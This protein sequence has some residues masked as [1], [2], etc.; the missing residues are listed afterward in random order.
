MVEKDYNSSI[1]LINMYI[2]ICMYTYY[3]YTHTHTHTHKP[4]HT[5]THTGLRQTASHRPCWLRARGQVWRYRRP[6]KRGPKHQ[7]VT[8]STRRLR[9]EPCLQE[10]TRPL[11]QL[12]TH[13]P[14]AGVKLWLWLWLC[15]CLWCV[16]TSPNAST[17]PSA[18]QGAYPLQISVPAP[19]L[20]PVTVRMVSKSLCCSWET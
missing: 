9:P 5:H 15:L 16:C 6:P 4:T 7:Q 3:V 13:L 8:L 20:V 10:Q 14:L 18:T 19:L 2:Y 1:S 12:Q 11:P 17:F